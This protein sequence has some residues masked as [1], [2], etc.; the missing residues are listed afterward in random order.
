MFIYREE[1]YD[2]NNDDVKG[3]A[4]VI[5][6]KQRNGPTGTITLTFLGE[7]T[8]FENY[9]ERSAYGLDDVDEA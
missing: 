9:T 8:R 7:Y 5:I 2:R 1:L 6:E 4:E 3:K